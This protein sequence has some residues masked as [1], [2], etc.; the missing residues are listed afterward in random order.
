MHKELTSLLDSL[1]QLQ[2]SLLLRHK[3]TRSLVCDGGRPAKQTEE[4]RV[5]ES[6]DEEVPSDFDSND[7]S[8]QH[9]EAE[10][11]EE[12]GIWRKRQRRKRKCPWVSERCVCAM[13][14]RIS[15]FSPS[16]SLSQKTSGYEDHI[17][18]THS[19]F[20]SYQD[21]TI[22]K[23][24]T[25]LRLASGKLTNKVAVSGVYTAVSGVYYSQWCV[26]CS[27]WCVLQSVVCTAVSGMYTAVSGVLWCQF[28]PGYDCFSCLFRHLFKWTD[29]L[30]PR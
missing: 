3:D 25:K 23:W 8:D 16:P 30:W 24:D 14:V 4:D 6:D 10:E 5:T 27:Q 19:A 9:E 12:K 28:C 29:Q 17:S 22:A 21:E 15:L 7:D 18:H 1:L 26:Y 13:F 20:Q 11:G 2:R